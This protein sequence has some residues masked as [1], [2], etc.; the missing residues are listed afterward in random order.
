[1]STNVSERLRTALRLAALVGAGVLSACGGKDEVT[2]PT[3][4]NP[5]VEDCVVNPTT[6]LEI[7]NACTDAQ[8]VDKN[9]VLPLLAADGSLPPLP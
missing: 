1:M 5:V 2:P 7:I 6:H 4:P 9:P 8:A 3:T